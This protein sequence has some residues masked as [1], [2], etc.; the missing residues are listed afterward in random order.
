PPPL[1]ARP[2]SGKAGAFHE[3]PAFFAFRAKQAMPSP[4]PRREP[5]QQAV[6]RGWQDSCK[7]RAD[8]LS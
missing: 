5:C 7:R 2:L 8:A 1:L 4:A 6:T 3:V